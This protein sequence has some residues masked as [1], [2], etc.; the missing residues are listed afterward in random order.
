MSETFEW[1]SFPEGRARFSGGIRGFDELGHETFAVEIDQA[2][3]FGEL[4]PKWLEDDVHFSIHI[5]SFGYL[6]RIEVGMPLP[7]FSTRSFTNDQ[8]ET[9]KVLVKKLIVAGL[10]FEDRPSSLMETKKSSFIGKVIFEQN[11]AL[12]TSNDASS[13]HE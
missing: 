10:Q 5:I 13:L 3:V 8:L 9:V 11:W 6:N 1:I 4:E 12:V 7:S 2:E